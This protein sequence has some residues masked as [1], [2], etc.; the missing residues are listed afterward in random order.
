MSS[1]Y[2]LLAVILVSTLAGS[3]TATSFAEE[4]EPTQ[5]TLID[6]VAHALSDYPAL[7]AARSRVAAAKEEAEQARADHGPRLFATLDGRRHGRPL[8]VTPIHG[9][10]VDLFPEFDR[11]L[12]QGNLQASYT[13]FDSGVRREMMRQAE[14]RIEAVRAGLDA[15]QKSI[16]ARV[17]TLFAETLARRAQVDAQA[18]RLAAVRAELGRVEQRL[19]VGKAPEVERLRAEAELAGAEADATSA[20]TALDNAERDLARLVGLD[21]AQTRAGRLV[22]PPPPPAPA[23]DRDELEATAVESSPLIARA[24][25][26]VALT[27][28]GHRLARTAYFPKLKASGGLQ[29]LGGSSLGFSSEWDVGLQLTVP[30]WD[31][32]LTDRRVAEASIGVEQARS[33]LRQAE[34]DVRQGVDHALA[35]WESASARERA[36]GRAEARLVEVARIQKLLLEV[37]SGTQVDYLAAESDLARTRADLA[38]ARGGMLSARVELARATGELDL[39]WLVKNL[40]SHP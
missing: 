18:Q 16:A 36:L 13:L 21:S 26:T 24:R 28:A 3:S 4:P 37:G 9:F 8:P 5:L 17:A 2:P 34:L 6:A 7:A 1:R 31:G 33:Q 12:V 14:A 20:S 40:E 22:A 19:A 30:L 39:D 27:E 23:R 11:T 35:A 38:E 15:D 32:G 10:G 29:E 25:S